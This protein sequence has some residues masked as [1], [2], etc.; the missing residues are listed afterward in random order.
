[1]RNTAGM[2]DDKPNAIF[3]QPISG[4]ITINLLVAFYNIHVGKREDF[5]FISYFQTAVVTKYATAC[6]LD[7][8]PL[9][10]DLLII[11]E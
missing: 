5:T 10:G 1:M 8:P 11:A 6:N 9:T 7:C 4:V 2:T 3:L